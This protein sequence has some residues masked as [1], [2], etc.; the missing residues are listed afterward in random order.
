MNE[1]IKVVERPDTESNR[2]MPGIM[3]IVLSKHNFVKYVILQGARLYTYELI[4][5]MKERGYNSISC[6]KGIAS[7]VGD[8]LVYMPAA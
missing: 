2:F 7:V 4:P 6:E 3:E 5:F 1:V 8:H